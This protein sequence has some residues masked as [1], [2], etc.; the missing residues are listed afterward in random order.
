[1]LSNDTDDRVIEPSE[2]RR[3]RAVDEGFGP[4]APWLASAVTGLVAIALLSIAAGPVSA[5]TRRWLRD[6]LEV[7]PVP[8]QASELRMALV[9]AVVAALA[10]LLAELLGHVLAHGGWVRLAG[11]RRARREALPARAR[12]VAAGWMF[13]AASAVGGALVALPW[14][15]SLP[16]LAERSLSDASWAV[17]AFVGAAA[18]GASLAAVALGLLQLRVAMRAFDRTLRMTRSEA[19]REAS[20]GSTRSRRAPSARWRLA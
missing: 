6:S 17:A 11:V 7:A 1:M 16:K 5:G 13:A 20:E 9:P 15:G 3:N 18:I 2:A 12:R 4:R 10:V 19:R 8:A 14:I